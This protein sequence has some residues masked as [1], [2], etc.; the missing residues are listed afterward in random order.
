M[1]K[2]TLNG[3]VGGSEPSEPGTLPSGGHVSRLRANWSVHEDGA[4]AQRLQ[5]EEINQHYHGNRQRNHQI[6]EDLPQAREEQV[7]EIEQACR[8]AE[9]RRR[10]LHEIE[11]QD[12]DLARHVQSHF[13]QNT[14]NA[15]GSGTPPLPVMANGDVPDEDDD[16]PR[17]IVY[18][19]EQ[20]QVKLAR[21]ALIKDEPV[22]ANNK[23]EHYAVS[24]KYPGGAIAKVPMTSPRRRAFMNSSSENEENVVSLAGLSQRDVVLS[25]RAEEQIEMEKHDQELARRLQSQIDFVESE[26]SKMAREAQDLE[27]A[28]MVHAK[29]KA[30]LKRAKERSRQKKLLQQQENPEVGGAGALAASTGPRTES[31][32]SRNSRNGHTPQHSFDGVAEPR[33]GNSFSGYFYLSKCCGYVSLHYHHLAYTVWKQ[34]IFELIQLYLKNIACNRFVYEC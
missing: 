10:A 9:E 29:E 26:D 11:S 7:R 5:S 22:Y 30:K 23:P 20:Y 13:Y 16:S 12:A 27:Y 25:R 1:L 2:F 32:N 34:Q 3:A 24:Q 8:V 4:L 19:D 15:T 14:Q 17:Q 21:P 6:R 31:R 18:N 33:I 28:K